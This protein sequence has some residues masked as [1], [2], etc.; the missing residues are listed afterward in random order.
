MRR[1]VRHVLVW[2][3]AFALVASAAAWSQC[4]EMQLAAAGVAA[5][6]HADHH[7]QAAEP[8]MH[9]HHDSMHHEHASGAPAAPAAGD[10]GCMKC[11]SMCT[12]A[13]ATLPALPGATV[14]TVSPAVFYP[15]HEN[16]SASTVAVD[17]G[18]P[19]RIV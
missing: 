2:T 13:T 16:W 8:A 15:D 9:E 17:P 10:H 14:F 3:V 12:V 19:K 6:E 18:I 5:A 11:C 7:I 4:T 1:I